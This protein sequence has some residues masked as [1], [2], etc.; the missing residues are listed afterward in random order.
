MNVKH[1]DRL[2]DW[3]QGRTFY[4]VRQGTQDGHTTLGED[5]SSLHRLD[6][7]Q[8]QIQNLTAD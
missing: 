8:F 1:G 5:D 2:I 4:L 3:Q 6:N 7:Q